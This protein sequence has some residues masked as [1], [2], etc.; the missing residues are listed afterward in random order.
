MGGER[1]KMTLLSNGE[2][3]SLTSYTYHS[4]PRHL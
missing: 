1:T 3:L 4:A 2:L